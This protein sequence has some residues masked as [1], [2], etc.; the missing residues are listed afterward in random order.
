M[1]HLRFYAEAKVRWGEDFE[2][3]LVETVL[4]SSTS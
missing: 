4:V 3:T 1:Q 2:T